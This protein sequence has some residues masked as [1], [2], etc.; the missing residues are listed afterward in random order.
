[1]KT[2]A[3]LIDFS[4]RSEHAAKYA[5]HLAKKIKA[6]VI[7][8]HLDL[9][10][11]SKKPVLTSGYPDDEAQDLRSEINDQLEAFSA[12]LKSQL[13]ERCSPHSFLPE[14][15]YDQ[16][17]QE[18]VD[19][20][21]SIVNN[22]DVILIVTAPPDSQDM[23][24]YMLSD[25]CQQIM[26]WAPV[27]VM[28]VPGTTIIRNP[29][30]IAITINLGELDTDYIN[31]LANLVAQFSPEIMVS[32]LTENHSLGDTFT[33]L[34]K[35]FLASIHKRVNY[36]RVYYRRII[37]GGQKGWKW[38]NDNKKCDVLAISHQQQKVL[39]EFFNLGRTP[40][41]SHHITIPVIVLP[42]MG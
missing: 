26:H 21:T 23:A 42:D 15:K 3:V 39:N 27:P 8:Y 33:H 1:M 35:K 10:P 19:V 7:L 20:M 29:E 41:V 36:G 24:A 37:V 16:D 28:I 17:N 11:V 6:D 40:E 2:I 34:E 12:R 38:L 4:E 14:I 18:I 22:D 32:H 25:H 13:I 31:V 5:L 9:V 30:K